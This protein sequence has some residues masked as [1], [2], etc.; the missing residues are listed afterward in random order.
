MMSIE[1]VN[2]IID[3][4]AAAG[5]PA[6]A[7]PLTVER[8][9]ALLGA[10][11]QPASAD[12]YWKT[13]TFAL[14]GGPF[15]GGELRLNAAGDGALLI[16]EPRDPPGLG[17][18]DV[19]RQALGQRQGMLPNPNIPPEGIDAEYYQPGRPRLA[20]QWTHRSHRLRSLVLEWSAP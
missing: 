13:Y 14:A 6:D 3:R 5:L 2:Q 16:L 11:L 1:T 20:L 9:S 17:L 4:L 7:A 10:P 8:F 12:S 19:N 18:S 15:R